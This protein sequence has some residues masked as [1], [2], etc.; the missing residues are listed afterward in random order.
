MNMFITVSAY[1]D[2][3][4]E[5]IECGILSDANVTLCSRPTAIG[6]EKNDRQISWNS[7]M[8]MASMVPN[9]PFLL[10][11]ASFGHHFKTTPRLL[12][13]L[14]FVILLFG[15]TCGVTKVNTDHWQDNFWT[16]TIISIVLINISSAI[17]QGGL[18]GLPGKFPPQYMGIIFGGQAFGGI[19]ASVTNVLVILLGVDPP[20]A[21]FFCFLVAVLFL[22]TALICFIVATRSEFFQYYLDE[23]KVPSTEITNVEQRVLPWN[24]F[25]TISVYGISVFLIFAVTLTCFPAITVFAKSSSP[26]S[27]WGTKYFIPVCCSVLF[28]VGDWLGR[29][30]AEMILWPKPGRF[31]MFFVLV[32]SL[33]RLAFIPLFMFC[34]IPDSIRHFTDG[35][36]VFKHDIAYVVIMALFSLSNGYLSCICMMSAP[37]LCDGSEVQTAT[38]MMVALLGLGFSTGSLM[39]YPIKSLL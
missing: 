2:Y 19:F 14:I 33:L 12:L 22:G 38:S 11:N 10:L 20:N 6:G 34:N 13:S 25:K 8:V 23:S 29:F 35:L 26:S 5:T 18:I 1:W 24:V 31:G 27:E 17:F 32:L 21:A 9:V 37:Q 30:S 28:N 3:K 39:S 4:W 16:G 36:G 7:N 15:V